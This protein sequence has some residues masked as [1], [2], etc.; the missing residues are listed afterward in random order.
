[1]RILDKIAVMGDRLF[2]ERPQL[3]QFDKAL[4]LARSVAWRGKTLPPRAVNLV[5]RFLLDRQSN[6]AGAGD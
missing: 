4:V 1:M 5:S 3:D 2:A 6:R